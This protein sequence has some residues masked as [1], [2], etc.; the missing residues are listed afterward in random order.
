[1]WETRRG[2]MGVDDKE[3]EKG[4]KEKEEKE[5]EEK[6][7]STTRN[8]PREGENRKRGTTGLEAWGEP[9]GADSA[10]GRAEKRRGRG[11]GGAYDGADT[12]T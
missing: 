6:G 7:E 1:M 8:Y 5:R 4:E 12:K 11:K 10:T 3:K 9:G 2:V